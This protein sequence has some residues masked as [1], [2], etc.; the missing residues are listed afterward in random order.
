MGRTILVKLLNVSWALQVLNL[1]WPSGI[2]SLM[3]IS[4]VDLNLSGSFADMILIPNAG[5]TEH[6]STA[7]LFVLTNPGQ[8]NV[9][10]GAILPSLKTDAGP[11]VQAERF[12]VVV[13]TIDPCITV[14]K[15]CLLPP[16]RDYFNELLKV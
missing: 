11:P 16:G 1:E 6:N 8:L 9:Y 13:P 3:C 4:R 5:A 2:D 14:T 7:A 12:P 10:D 15:I